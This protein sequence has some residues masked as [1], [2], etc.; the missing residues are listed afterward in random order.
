MRS[1][2]LLSLLLLLIGCEQVD[3]EKVKTKKFYARIDANATSNDRVKFTVILNKSHIFGDYIN[4]VGNDYLDARVSERRRRLNKD[5][6][7]FGQIKYETTFRDLLNTSNEPITVTLH[8]DATEYLNPLN[9]PQAF[10]MITPLE[11]DTYDISDNDPVEITWDNISD[12][13]MQ[14]FLDLQ[15]RY[16]NFTQVTHATE[17][18]WTGED[19]GYMSI[20]TNEILDEFLDRQE[21]PPEDITSCRADLK[22]VRYQQF[23]L[24]IYFD[25]GFA[26]ARQTRYR[27]IYFVP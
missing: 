2:F 6:S 12:D 10:N 5:E 16:G 4:L 17:A 11:E 20:N 14:L 3:S 23:P 26:K 19:S 18:R 15:C 24:N 13:N 9:L 27:T 7:L 25:G 1:V 8:R 21:P 22:L